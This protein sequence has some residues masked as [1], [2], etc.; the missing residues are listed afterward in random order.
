VSF[1]AIASTA[2]K[3]PINF[4]KG[5]SELSTAVWWS[6][7]FTSAFA[8]YFKGSI[9][10]NLYIIKK[11]DEGNWKRGEKLPR[12]GIFLTFLCTH[13]SRAS[14]SQTGDKSTISSIKKH[15]A[16]DHS[17][18]YLSLEWDEYKK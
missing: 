9:D 4:S 5:H 16:F 3:C 13:I 18:F 12:R 6:F 1:F 17:I 7:I 11:R 2:F 15:F 14:P 8:M 10:Y